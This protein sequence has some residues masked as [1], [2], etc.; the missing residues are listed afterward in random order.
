MR[1]GLTLAVV[2]VVSSLSAG[3][4]LA[5]PASDTKTEL[6][7]DCQAQ[8]GEFREVPGTSAYYCVASGG[9]VTV[10]GG[11]PAKCEKH[12]SRE[13]G[14]KAL[15]GAIVASQGTLIGQ[16]EK[17]I[18]DLRGI[19]VDLKDLSIKL[20]DLH[21]ACAPPDLLPLP[22][23]GSEPPGY[24]RADGGTNL[25]VR[26]KNQGFSDAGPSTLRVTFSTPG[27]PVPVDVAVGGVN[28]GTFLDVPV[29]I[30]PACF[31]PHDPFP[32]ACNFQI[33]VDVE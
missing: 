25:I 15:L 9:T 22:I 2:I 18:A 33:A 24:C 8:G 6:R 28:F 19:I 31:D 5:K 30:P 4:A 29:A 27:G 11:S 16:Q 17:V 26:V 10:C 14:E 20:D 1:T 3:P 23:E 12:D 32:H 13:H 7:N 21:T